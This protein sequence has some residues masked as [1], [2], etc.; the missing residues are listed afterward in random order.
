MGGVSFRRHDL[1]CW[2]R[3]GCGRDGGLMPGILTCISFLFPYFPLDQ[4]F[5][6]LKGNFPDLPIILYWIIG[7]NYW[8]F[9]VLYF[10]LKY[11]SEHFLGYFN[12]FFNIFLSIFENFLFISLKFHFWFNFIIFII[13]HCLFYFYC[14]QRTPSNFC[15]FFFDF[16]NLNS[17]WFIFIFSNWYL[18]FFEFLF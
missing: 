16:L 15:L 6:L 13:F 4:V 1:W 5:I 11:L 2:A 12:I 3:P 17:F 10:L 18:L 9:N 8:F 7:N 14:Y